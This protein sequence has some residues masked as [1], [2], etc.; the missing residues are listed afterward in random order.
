M[1]LSVYAALTAAGVLAGSILFEPAL[2]AAKP[3]AEAKAKDKP[4]KASGAPGELTK[5]I[6]LSPAGLKWGLSLNAIAKL[7]DKEFD[8]EFVPLYK[9]VE[10]GPRMQALDAEL[11]ERKALIRRNKIEFGKLPTGV[12]QGA[13]KGEYSYNNGE[14]MTH[15]T[16]RNG[17]R[18][19]FFFFNDKLWK[20]YDEHP[21]R[22]SGPLGE[23]YAEAIKILT[24]RF[25][26]PPKVVEQ[27]YEK[28]QNY[29]E[30]HWRDSSNVI[31]AINREPTL[32]LVYANPSIQD[33]LA[34]LR[35]NK[36]EDP[37]AIDRDVASV[38]KKGEPEADKSKEPKK[39]EPAPSGKKTK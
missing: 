24:K 23:N 11:A 16:L 14:S 28:G 20:I 1:K 15:L 2:A 36:P 38:T 12:D 6:G 9:K 32:A 13:L 7:Y 8:D 22:K 4:K 27:D 29:E 17:T 3:P 19:Y 18:R 35:K 21:L 39:A 5:R 37:H 33:S 26:A 30:A 10:P 31:R 34:T 25:G